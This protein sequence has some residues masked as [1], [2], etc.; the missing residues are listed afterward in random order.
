[1]NELSNDVQMNELSNGGCGEKLVCFE[2]GSSDVAKAFQQ[3]VF[4]YGNGE[5]AIELTAEMPVFTCKAC[6]FQF[7]GPEG[8]DARHEAVCRHLGLLTPQEIVSIREHAGLSQAQFA[9]RTRIGIASLKRWETG[10]VIQ[11][12]ANDE[13]IYLMTFPDNIQ[14]LEERSRMEPLGNSVAA[15]RTEHRGTTRF[16]ARCLVPQGTLLERSHQWALRS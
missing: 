8:D 7:A 9:R 3:Q 16:R 4:Q 11:N 12:A 15:P 10:V 14:R 6:G 13:L 5:N 2:C 1:M